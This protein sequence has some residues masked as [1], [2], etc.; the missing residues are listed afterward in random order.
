MEMTHIDPWDKISK[1]HGY[2]PE[3]TAQAKAAQARR[4]AAM[5]AEQNRTAAIGVMRQRCV[6]GWAVHIIL[7]AAREHQICPHDIV[8]N[9]RAYRVVDARNDAIYRI[10]A[11]KPVLSSPRLGQWFGKDHTS[12]IYA[13]AYHSIATGLPKLTNYTMR[14]RK[15]RLWGRSALD[16]GAER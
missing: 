15:G 16:R 13:L 4:R 11:R 1:F 9:C 3:F 7:E 10:K 14:P 5:L 2:S 12:I 8:R 6:P